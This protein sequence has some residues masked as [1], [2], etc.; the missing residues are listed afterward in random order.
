MLLVF[1]ALFLAR[2]SHA[3]PESPSLRTSRAQI[4]ADIAAAQKIINSP[5]YSARVKQVK[6]RELR[7]LQSRLEEGDLQPGDQILLSVQG[8]KDLTG[9]F[10]VSGTRTITLPGL[11]DVGLRGVLRSELEDHLRQEIGK[12]LRNPIVHVQ[13]TVRVSIL[14]SVGKPG[15]YQVESGK[16]VGDAIMV[17]GGPTPGID[18]AKT[19]VERAGTII[20]DREAFNAAL[21]A[22]KTIDQMNLRAG[23]EIVVGGGRTLTQNRSVLNTVLPIVTG[24]AT[25]TIMVA[26]IVQ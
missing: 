14:G 9:T 4:E 25:L 15:F 3:Q 24:L 16:M 12:Y 19:Q 8:E 22:G 18:P 26:Q 7:L 6:R 21:T 10:P 13:T 11:T 17:A 20:L 2:E 23:D 1:C 5:G